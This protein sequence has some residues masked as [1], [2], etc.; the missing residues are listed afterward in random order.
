MSLFYLDGEDAQAGHGQQ[1]RATQV[2]EELQIK[3]K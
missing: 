3:Q 1:E 2:A